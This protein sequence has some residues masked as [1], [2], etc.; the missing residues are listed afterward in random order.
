MAWFSRIS[1]LEP[2]HWWLI[3][4]IP[5]V[6]PKAQPFLI[7]YKINSKLRSSL[8]DKASYDL[9]FIFAWFF[10][11][12]FFF[13]TTEINWSVFWEAPF[14]C[15]L[16]LNL[17]HILFQP[18]D[19]QPLICLP[20][21]AHSSLP[22]L[23]SFSSKRS[24]CSPQ[25]EAVF[26]PSSK[27]PQYFFWIVGVFISIYFIPP[28]NYWHPYNKYNYYLVSIYWNQILCSASPH[29]FFNLCNP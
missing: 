2:F 5:I 23:K 26:P 9:T 21:K 13:T 28:L 17:V 18:P 6:P 20:D 19:L 24:L 14:L 27:L 25:K 29:F 15:C 4:L 3:V 12:I 7:A 22:G 8:A 16:D 10:F 11:L 1:A